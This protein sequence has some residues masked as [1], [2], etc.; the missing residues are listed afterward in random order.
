MALNA[1]QLSQMVRDILA[2]RDDELDCNGCFEQLDR[3]V[4][5]ELAGVDAAAA[6]P[7]VADHLRRCRDCREEYE[8]LLVALQALA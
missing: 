8:A 1:D 3:F 2:Y 5:M 7:L 6:L 4:E